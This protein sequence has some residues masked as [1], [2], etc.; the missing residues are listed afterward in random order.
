MWIPR[1]P[2]RAPPPPA[3]LL[4]TG[5]V[6]ATCYDIEPSI[7]LCTLMRGWFAAQMKEFMIRQPGVVEVEWN[8]VK[9]KPGDVKDD[10]DDD[11]D[12]VE[13]VGKRRKKAPEI[14]L[15]KPKKKPQAKKAGS[16]GKAKGGRADKDE[17]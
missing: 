8:Q 10:D 12:G 7:L 4:F 9:Y 2:S 6:N 1:P 15:P 14:K 17:L 13:V 11:D 5:G 3:Q 16:G